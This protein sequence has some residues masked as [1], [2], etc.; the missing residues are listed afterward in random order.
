MCVCVWGGGGGGGGGQLSQG[1][2]FLLEIVTLPICNHSGHN[3]GTDVWVAA[4]A[5][6]VPETNGS[7]FIC[8]MRFHCNVDDI[9]PCYG[10]PA[11]VI[12]SKYDMTYYNESS[13]EQ[14]KSLHVTNQV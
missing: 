7:C 2:I 6:E 1:K 4:G 11:F 8:P 3:S 9:E 10:H 5:A 13:L 12:C 14:I